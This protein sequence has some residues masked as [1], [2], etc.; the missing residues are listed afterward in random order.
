MAEDAEK[1][2][3]PTPKKI[4]DAKKEGN[5]PKSMDFTG[6]FGL[7]ISFGAFL[8][9]SSFMYQNLKNELYYFLSTIGKPL[10]KSDVAYLSFSALKS[11][12]VVALPIALAVLVAGV[13]GNLAQFGFIFTTKP[14]TPDLKKIDPIKG[15]KNLF[16]LKKLIDGLKITAKVAIAFAVGGYFFLDY[17]SE[18]PK[19]ERFDFVDQLNWLNDKGI[20]IASVM[21]LVFFV[22]GVIDIAI[23]RYRYF[24]DLR[25]SKNEIKDEFKQTEGNPE[26]KAKIKQIQRQISQN[27]MMQDVPKADVVITN[28]TH[29]AVAILYEKDV[30]VPKVVAKGADI[31]AVKIK[32]IARENG[33]M[34]YENKFLA[35]E[36]YKRVDV[37]E[38]IPGDLFAAVAEVLAFVYKT[39]NK[40]F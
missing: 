20:A 1:T 38:S 5:V 32:E 25:M 11:I 27:K 23:V 33:V 22:F 16:S 7:L 29:F 31:I 10:T 8:A 3:E 28:P 15:L 24:K 39:N 12:M 18:L 40:G 21:L 9:L 36:L 14:L 34:I 19:I 4:E 26:V 13:I 17:I 30:G 35:R 2:E 6:F 37:G